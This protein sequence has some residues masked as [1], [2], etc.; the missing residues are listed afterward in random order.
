[1]MIR[2]DGREMTLG[3]FMASDGLTVRG[4]LLLNG[5]A[6][7][8][9]LP[10][11]LTV[12]KSMDLSGCAALTALPDGL[13]VR[14][15]LWL[16]GCTALTALPPGLTVHGSLGL[17]ECTA[18]TALPP[19]LTVA[20]SLYLDGCAALTAL[21]DNLTVGRSLWLDGC[22]NIQNI[23]RA[24]TDSRGYAFYGVRLSNGPCVIAG[25][26]NFNLDKAR[27]HWRRNPECLALAERAIEMLH[28]SQE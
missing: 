4:S 25:C 24:G 2:V 14:G 6:G 22:G 21:P 3:E 13:T 8:T 15:S 17:C 12:N 11:G 28:S 10:P 18:L 7:L 26:R 16:I 5:C 1:M 20:W 19:G 23:S 27:Q 9:A